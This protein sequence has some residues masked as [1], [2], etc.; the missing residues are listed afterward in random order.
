[1]A[2]FVDYMKWGIQHG[3]YMAGVTSAA[4][5]LVHVLDRD[6]VLEAAE[7]LKKKGLNS[8]TYMR[9]KAINVWN[10]WGVVTMTVSSLALMLSPFLIG[11]KVYK[12]IK[13]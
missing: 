11:R 4:T 2:T 10:A 12:T 3:E 1:M 6:E 13:K 9:L 5:E 7:D 8:D